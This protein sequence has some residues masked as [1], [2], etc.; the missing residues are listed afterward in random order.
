MNNELTDRELMASLKNT[1]DYYYPPKP[2][3]SRT[4]LKKRPATINA[5]LILTLVPF[6]LVA[7]STNKVFSI[8]QSFIFE[9]SDG[10]CI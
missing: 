2:V 5:V 7:W 10:K 4:Q 8:L 1:I 9:D 6:A 3:K